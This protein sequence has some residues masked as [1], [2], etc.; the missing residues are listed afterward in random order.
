M[1]E[2]N[3]SR[4]DTMQNEDLEE[5]NIWKSKRHSELFLENVASKLISDKDAKIDKFAKNLIRFNDE[6]N[7]VVSERKRKVD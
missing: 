7:N 5:S 4:R 1:E 6:I 2:I 3:E